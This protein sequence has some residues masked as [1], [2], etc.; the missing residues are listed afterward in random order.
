[1]RQLSQYYIKMEFHTAITKNLING[2]LKLQIC[3]VKSAESRK[4]TVKS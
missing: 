3:Y 2:L 1:M 4:S